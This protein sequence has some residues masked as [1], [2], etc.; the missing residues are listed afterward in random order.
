MREA[1]TTRPRGSHPAGPRLRIH[2]LGGFAV[3]VDGRPVPAT[4]WRLRKASEL[5]KLL[6]LTSGHRLHR[7]QVIEQLWPERPPD[8]GVNNFHQA[9]H[10][11]RVA[12]GAVGKGDAQRILALREGV[13]GFSPRV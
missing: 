13:L 11:A 8:A 9:L 3:E 12:L 2:L 1:T 5:V 7:E 6:A 4:A 10:V